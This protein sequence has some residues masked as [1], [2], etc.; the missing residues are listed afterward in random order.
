MDDGDADATVARGNA[1]DV[2]ALA[3]DFTLYGLDES[4]VG[5]RWIAGMSGPGGPV[6]TFGLSHVDADYS[7]GVTVRTID[8]H[9]YDSW[10]SG[11]R[12]DPEDAVAEE[13][14][15]DLLA[16][17]WPAPVIM[18]AADWLDEVAEYAA[19]RARD[20]HSWDQVS[21]RVDGVPVAAACWRFAGA[22]TGFTTEVPGTYVVI[23]AVNVDPEIGLRSLADA[24]PY[25]FQLGA[26]ITIAQMAI[27]G[28]L[29]NPNRNGF[30]ADHHATRRPSPS[31]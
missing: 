18:D 30:H 7:R 15:D 21:W 13:A 3:P 14:V 12:R 11:A 4:W 9:R 26:D 28:P 6:V 19:A 24:A 16:T 25:G 29:P 10:Q 17:T 5:A 27:G 23:T 2:V 8:R 20:R 1:D 22:W 31:L